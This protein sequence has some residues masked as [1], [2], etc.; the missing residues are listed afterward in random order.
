MSKFALILVLFLW[1]S[2]YAKAQITTSPQF[3]V[4]AKEVILTFD[5]RLDN[6]LNYFTSDLYAHTGV[7]VEGNTLWQN[8]IGQ[9]GQNNI[10]P[11]LTHLGDGIYQLKISPDIR[12]FYS[13][14]SNQKVQKLAFVFRSS[15]G[16]KQT[17]DLF[18]NVFADGLALELKGS[19]EGEI[20]DQGQAYTWTASTSVAADLQLFF[21]G[22]LLA[23]HSGTSVT[24]QKTFNSTA[25]G[26]MVAVAT[27]DNQVVK[28]SV[29]VFVREQTVVAPLPSA[30]RKGIS[31]PSDHSA[32]LVLWAPKKS[33]VFVIGDFNNWKPSN[34]YQMKRQGDYFWID[35][36]GLEKG[37]PYLFQYYID[38]KIKVADAYTEQTSDPWY[39]HQIKAETYP[40]LPRFPEGKTTGIA[41]VLQPGLE[42]YQWEITN[43]V[44]PPVEKMVIYEMLIRDFTHEHTYESILSRLDYL[45]DL[46][47]NVL[48]LMPLT[49]SKPIAV[50][51]ITLPSFLP[52]TNTTVTAISLKN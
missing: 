2:A 52:P 51:V 24:T 47:V 21:Q 49:S 18:V 39:D 25:E 29:F 23:T 30:A 3:P 36:T 9:W 8:V 41:S 45:Q 1:I 33:F 22:Q 15:D 10:Q 43:F 28:D 37:E 5:S 4:V 14:T 7:L 34:Q 20:Y 32:R 35:L 27:T 46:R 44:M 17:N 12:S 38:G 13:I 50:G 40:G 6:R 19:F 48:E 42:P 11:K 16:S 26:W 31:Y